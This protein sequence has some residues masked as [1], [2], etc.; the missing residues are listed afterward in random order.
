MRGGLSR[1]PRLLVSLQIALCLTALVAAG[2][3][4]RSLEKLKWS[5]IGFD[6]ENLA[7]ASVSPARAGYASRSHRDICHAR[8]PR[9]G[10]TAR[11]R[12]RECRSDPAAVGRRQLGAGQFSRPA[13]GQDHGA[14][15]NQSERRSSRR[16]AFRS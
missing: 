7:Y 11:R 1:L 12:E 2:L 10:T 14:N 4:G 13:V 8:S 3:L 6:R 16:C 15:M 5:D 9:A